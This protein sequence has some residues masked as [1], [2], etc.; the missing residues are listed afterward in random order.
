LRGPPASILRTQF[1]AHHHRRGKKG[2]GGKIGGEK[3]LAV[4]SRGW[5][6]WGMGG[7][8]KSADYYTAAQLNTMQGM[9]TRRGGGGEG[10]GSKIF[11]MNHA[12]EGEGGR[13]GGKN[14]KVCSE[15]AYHRAKRRKKK[16]KEGSA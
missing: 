16:K 11:G 2:G 14:G 3:P 10:R 13:R 6:S 7:K 8:K 5:V 9:I 12:P 4:P 1:P 15:S